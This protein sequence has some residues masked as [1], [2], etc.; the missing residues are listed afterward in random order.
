MIGLTP[1][2]QCPEGVGRLPKTRTGVG[3]GG[4]SWMQRG[5]HSCLPTKQT[6]DWKRE[7]GVE[8]SCR[9]E[10]MCGSDGQAD[11]VGL[12]LRRNEAD[13]VSEHR[14]SMLIGGTKVAGH[15]ARRRSGAGSN[16]GCSPES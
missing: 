12:N 1:A 13:K 6:P 11:Q 2:R 7:A 14:L 4:E 5:V 3:L 16:V 9:A 10:R 8:P 15:D